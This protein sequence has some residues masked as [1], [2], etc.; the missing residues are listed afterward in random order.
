MKKAL[1]L[2]LTLFFIISCTGTKQYPIHEKPFYGLKGN[3]KSN[4]VI[5]YKGEEKFGE[6]I[7]GNII[8]MSIVEFNNDGKAIKQ[9]SYDEDGKLVYE[10]VTEYKGKQKTKITS[11][12]ND[13]DVPSIDLVEVGDG[14]IKQTNSKDE[15]D[16]FLI[17]ED[18]VDKY[19]LIVKNQD[20][21]VFLEEYYNTN[22]DIVKQISYSGMDSG[23]VNSNTIYEY[24]DNGVCVSMTKTDYFLKEE[25]EA[26]KE[27][28]K[29]L[30]TDKHGNWTK[31]L[32]NIQDGYRYISKTEIEVRE[33]SYR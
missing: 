9:T 31:R 28:Y 25:G 13:S 33:I 12:F 5:R 22:C 32:I 2:I 16:Y 21:Q 11:Q 23:K 19:H 4:K 26:E 27:S 14:Y 18:E 10:I 1:L 6:A 20:N 7:L 8:S 17:V 29:Y 15:N 30:E 24:D 3:V